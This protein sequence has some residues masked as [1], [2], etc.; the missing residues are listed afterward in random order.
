MKPHLRITVQ[1]LLSTDTPQREIERRT[2]VDRKTIRS[3]ARAMANSPGVATG[4]SESG[5]QIPPPRPP[6]PEGGPGSAALAPAASACEPYR[7]WIE[8]Q[9]VL[10]RNA[11]S[12]YQDLVEVH[13]FGHAHNSSKRFVAT[14]R[15][16]EPERFDVLEVLPGEEAQVD[17]GQG[18]L[19]A[20]GGGKYRRPYLF[21]MTLK[22]FG[23]SFRKT[24]WKTSQEA[25]ARLH[26]QAFRALGG[27]PA[28]IVLD[29]LK[30]GVI[31]P[32]LYAPELNPV[33]AAMLTHYGVVAD[34]CRVGDPN[35]KGTVESAI[36]HT[37]ATALKGRRFDSV[38][39]QN[40]WLAHWEERWAATR[41]H[42]RKK[43][44]VLEMYR[45]ELP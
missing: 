18:A 5:A 37:Q 20:V 24:V 28:Y 29:N 38:G 36:Q 22:F 11:V 9:V 14:I 7:A 23:K 4:F 19:T 1:T 43:R 17:Y 15:K 35:R 13:G 44:Q 27:C 32:D 33:Y 41:I 34:T 45:E 30:E 3:H 42:G 31:R 26:E 40:T 6:A 12:I 16:R 25:W 2:G 21:V 39:A 10:G 8:A